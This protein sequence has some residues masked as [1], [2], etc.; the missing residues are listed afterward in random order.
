VEDERVLAVVARE[1]TDAVGREE[2]VLV[3]QVAEDALELRRLRGERSR[4]PA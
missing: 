1:G 2:L 4:R 3:E